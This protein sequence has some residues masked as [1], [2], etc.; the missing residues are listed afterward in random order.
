MNQTRII[1]ADVL[2]ALPTLGAESM[3]AC[4]TDPPYGLKF[5]GKM[6]DHG[7]PGEA[8]WRE[9]LRVLK[10]GAMLLAFGGTRTHHRLMVAIEDAG[11]EIRDCLMWLYG[12]GFPKSLDISKAIDKAAGAERKTIAEIPDRWTGKGSSL[13]FSTDRPQETVNVQPDPVTPA[14]HTWQGYGTALKPAW[15]PIILAMKPLDGTFAENALKHGVAGLNVDGGRIDTFRPGEYERLKRRGDT[16]RQDFT[17]GR[18]HS[19]AEYTPKVIESGMSPA[20][21]WPANVLLD[22]DTTARLDAEAGDVPSGGRLTGDE[23]RSQGFSGVCCGDGKGPRSWEPYAD[24][25]GPSRFFYTAK[26]SS[27]ERGEDNSHPTVKPVDLAAYLAKLIL[28]P[29]SPRHLLVPFC[30]SGSEIIGALR[31]GWDKVTGIELDPEYALLAHN[32]IR[33]DAPLLNT[34]MADE[35]T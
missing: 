33:Q 6:W 25:G 31:A 10:P 13:N 23:P 27:S 15:E 24:N 19:G 20:G 28:P 11:F 26:A 2:E 32:R 5:M 1:Q 3:D 34:V 4:L 17:G 8:V 16:P 29:E 12:S 22:E 7:V 21:R 9:V 14:A 30:G 35:L 18:L